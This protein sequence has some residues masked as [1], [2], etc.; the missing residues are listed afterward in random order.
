LEIK[1]K[2]TIAIFDFC[3]TLVSIQTANDFVT[4][5]HKRNKNLFSQTNEI[6]R[7]ICRKIGLLYGKRHK[8]WQLKQLRG[9]SL[10]NLD[11]LAKH[12]VEKELMQYE[13]ENIVRKL[14]WH[15]N[16]GHEIVICSG[17]FTSYIKYYGKII[18]ADY[19]IATDLEIENGKLTGKIDGDDCMGIKKIKK[20]SNTLDINSIDLEQSFAYSDNISDIPLLSFVGNGVVVDFGQDISWA[21]LMQYGVISAK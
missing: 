20:L 1:N 13:N 5:C 19:V 18:Q 9:I 21:Q 17:G 14:K 7:T 11:I 2:K 8:N 3:E 16:Q 12:Y 4:Y 6:I 15:K 10:E